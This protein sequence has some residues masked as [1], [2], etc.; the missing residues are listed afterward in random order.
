MHEGRKMACRDM[1]SAR[2]AR[3]A[4]AEWGKRNARRHLLS[5]IRYPRSGN[6][7]SP[8]PRPPAFR[9]DGG[10]WLKGCQ[11]AGMRRVASSRFFTGRET[12]ATSLLE[13]PCHAG[14]SAGNGK[15][16]CKRLGMLEQTPMAKC[17][18]VYWP[19]SRQPCFVEM[20][21]LTPF[22]FR[23]DFDNQM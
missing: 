22:T 21:H 19:R 1:R 20:R 11:R 14:E 23:S 6:S 16:E 7:A 8:H 18:S 12:A 5:T 15:R 4:C 13:S 3:R 17:E 10:E 9:R 2:R